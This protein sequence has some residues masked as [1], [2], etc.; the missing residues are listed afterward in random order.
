MEYDELSIFLRLNDKWDPA[1]D[2]VRPALTAK[3]IGVPGASPSSTPLKLR[4]ASTGAPSTPTASP[5]KSKGIA[6]ETSAAASALGSAKASQPTPVNK[7]E[8]EKDMGD[9]LSGF[10]LQGVKATDDELLAL[11]EELGLGKDEADELVKGLSGD[12]NATTAHTREA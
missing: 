5:L 1:I 9:E 10:G 12:S 2:E 8:G 11:V 3:P 6:P 4:V 7:R